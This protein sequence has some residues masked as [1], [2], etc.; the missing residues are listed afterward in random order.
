MK[1][2]IDYHIV[3]FTKFLYIFYNNYFYYL[4]LKLCKLVLKKIYGKKTYNIIYNHIG[5]P[6]YML[7]ILFIVII[8]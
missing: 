8:R 4:F 3:H 6:V 2:F 5:S 1:K 7:W